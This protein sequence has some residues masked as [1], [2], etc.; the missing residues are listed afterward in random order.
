MTHIITF[1]RR[2]PAFFWYLCEGAIIVGAWYWYI[3]N[4]WSELQVPIGI[5]YP[6][7]MHSLFVWELLQQ[8]G[9]CAWWANANGGYPVFADVFG[10]FLHPI[11]FIA[12]M[13]H[14]AIAGSATTVAWSFLL[15]GG[16]G[17][18]FGWRF[19][20]HPVAR[21]WLSLALMYGGH[22]ASRLELGTVGM[23]LSLAAAWL[24][25]VGLFDYFER[26]SLTKAVLSGVFIGTFLLSGQGY[27]QLA[28]VLSIPLWLGLAWHWGWLRLPRPVLVQQV[29]WML[30][31]ALLI[32]A[33][34]VLNN[35][36]YGTYFAKYGDGN[37]VMAQPIE[38]VFM[39]LMLDDFELS[40][41]DLYN[42]LPYPWAYSVFIGVQP[43]LMA[44]GL[45]G[46]I[47][48][49]VHR[50]LAV[51]LAVF[52]LMQLFLASMEPLKWLIATQI[53]W[54]ADNAAALRFLLLL[55]GLAA[56]AILALAALGL[57]ALLTLP[58]PQRLQWPTGRWAGL[59][60]IGAGVVVLLVL[61]WHLWQLQ[62]FGRIWIH[63]TP[64]RTPDTDLIAQDI[65]TQLPG[66]VELEGDWMIFT[67]LD[68]RIK[69]NDLH[70][71]WW[72]D[73]TTPPPARYRVTQEL[74]PGFT[75]V[76]EYTDG[77]KLIGRADPAFAYAAFIDMTGTPSECQ[78]TAL[79]GH[80][81]L[82]C[83]AP[84]PGFV[85]V[86]EHALPGWV[87]AVNGVRV[88]VETQDGW[89]RVPVPAGQVAVSFR[90]APWQAPAG[91]VLAGIGWGLAAYQ[92][93]RRSPRAER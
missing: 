1:I 25:M 19:G 85:H 55:N 15:I 32:A 71:S 24:C 43:V 34:L 78:A 88:P 9:S 5:E 10:S 42:P 93:L 6:R 45:W 72:I 23:T 64:A 21:I 2:V 91:L 41:S 67:L 53:R 75:L 49:P 56:V 54:L 68:E 57:H 77:W 92:L 13:Q 69:I 80:I 38:H 83:T 14:G 16:A 79:G 59:L 76:R 31:V 74:S 4:V 47:R 90:F 3:G 70:M 60:R 44:V 37:L 17:W 27:M 12:T 8:C 28:L 81:D 84:S 86:Y 66:Y 29:T 48:Q 82:A 36:T 58:W 50:A 51:F 73:R 35:L 11:A 20:L 52:A 89:I 30:G 18:Y 46:I 62:Q 65:A 40:K 22:M 61:G 87:A 39:N 26:P 33:P 7:N 63:A